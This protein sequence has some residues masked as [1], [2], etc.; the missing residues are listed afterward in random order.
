VTAAQVAL[1]PGAELVTD[2]ET[3]IAVISVA[4]TAEEMEEAEA[5]ALELELEPTAPAPAPE[6]AE[7]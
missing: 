7:S 2:P 3:A 6:A 1:P 4:P 5:P